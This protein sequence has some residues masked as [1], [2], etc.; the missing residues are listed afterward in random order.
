IIG[1]VLAEGEKAPA[2]PVGLTPVPAARPSQSVTAST[3][4]GFVKATP[5][6]RRLA[7]E[8]GISLDDLTGSGPAGRIVEADVLAAAERLPTQSARDEEPPIYGEQIRQRI[9]LSGMRRAIG[10]RLK[11]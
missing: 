1:Y 11:Q 4:G 9:P 7:K 5:M 3:A 6:A 2:A 10:E 8:R